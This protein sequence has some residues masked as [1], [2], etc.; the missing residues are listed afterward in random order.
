[1]QDS[2]ETERGS[3]FLQCLI[4]RTLTPMLVVLPEV[5]LQNIE[6]DMLAP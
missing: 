5:I 3:V 1:M 2:H 6:L 4:V